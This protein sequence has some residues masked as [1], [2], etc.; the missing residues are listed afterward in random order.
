[1]APYCVL[2]E[3][4]PGVLA[5]AATQSAW[6]FAEAHE[7]EA[8]AAHTAAQ[9]CSRVGPPEPPVDAPPEPGAIAPPEPGP[10]DP[11]APEPPDPAPCNPPEPGPP[12]PPEPESPP[13]PLGPPADG[14]L[15]A[16]RPRSRPMATR[17]L[18]LVRERP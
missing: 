2:H 7:E 5:D 16:A 4:L 17:G 10:T 8:C 18:V 12:T 3:T 15:Q 11:P 9:D 6:Q 13:V 14:P 1:M